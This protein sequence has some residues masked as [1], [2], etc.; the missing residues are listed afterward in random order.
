MLDRIRSFLRRP[1][2][3]LAVIGGYIGLNILGACT[4]YINE[5]ARDQACLLFESDHY[6]DVRQLERTYRYLM[7]PERF[8]D[9]KGS[10]LYRV[11]LKD[12]PRLEGEASV[13]TAPEFCDGGSIFHGQLGRDEPDPAIPSRP[14]IITDGDNPPA[15]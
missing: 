12:L 13:D 6:A 3:Y 9:H 10:S 8:N 15:P 5:E 1:A 2:T 4:F 11:V 14:N 7:F